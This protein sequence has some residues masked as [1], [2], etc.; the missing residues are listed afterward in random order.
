MADVL[1]AKYVAGRLE[2]LCRPD[3]RDWADARACHV[4]KGVVHGALGSAQVVEGQSVLVAAVTADIAPQLPHR[5]GYGRVEVA[6][7][8][9]PLAAGSTG[10]SGDGPVAAAPSAPSARTTLLMTPAHVKQQPRVSAGATQQQQ[11]L[12]KQWSQEVEDA[13][14]TRY[15]APSGSA[16]R[17]DSA[18]QPT[19]PVDFAAL[20][21]PADA[22]APPQCWRLLVEVVVLSLDAAGF[23]LCL[24]ATLSALHNTVLPELVHNGTTHPERRL[25]LSGVVPVV[26]TSVLFADVA[27]GASAALIDPTAE[28]TVALPTVGRVTLTST[29]SGATTVPSAAASQA[30][31][32]VRMTLVWQRDDERIAASAAVGDD[33]RPLIVDVSVTHVGRSSGPT[34]SLP[35]NA[36]SL[37][38]MEQHMRRGALARLHG[39]TSR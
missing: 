4:L 37:D 18:A 32:V 36:L 9:S 5:V 31:A 24:V 34:A 22:G 17:E 25:A 12:A 11:R 21:L 1:R 15:H 19:R 33:E 23:D 28:E 6:V 30:A 10:G 7:S 35:R 13:L 27:D 26:C 38:A 8:F 20:S 16:K 3:G 29:T 2:A 14:W 39:I